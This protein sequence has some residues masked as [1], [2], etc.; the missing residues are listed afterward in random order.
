[1]DDAVVAEN[2]ELHVLVPQ[3]TE[4]DTGQLFNDIEIPPNIQ[5]RSLL[6]FGK[7]LMSYH[8]TLVVYSSVGE[9]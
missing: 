9:C 6:Y 4:R 3:F 8:G 7:A 1:M 2:S 5:Q